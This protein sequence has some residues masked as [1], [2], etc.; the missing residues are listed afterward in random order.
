MARA[1]LPLNALRAFESSARHLS[2][3][4]AADELNV[5]QA[6]VS[7]HLQARRYYRR[8]DPAIGFHLQCRQV[9]DM[10][11]TH[12][13][14]MLFAVSRVVMAT[15]CFAGSFLAVFFSWIAAGILVDMTAV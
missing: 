1:H 9:A 3:T 4:L 6:A 10:A 5:T 13:A 8:I 12:R 15:G 14:I 7:Q 11:F 2:F